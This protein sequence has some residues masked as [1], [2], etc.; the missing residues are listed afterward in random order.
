MGI[1]TECF[2]QVGGKGASTSEGIRAE[3]STGTL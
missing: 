2:D 1:L 3:R